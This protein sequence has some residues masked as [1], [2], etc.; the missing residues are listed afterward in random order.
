LLRIN[1]FDQPAV[2]ESKQL[3]REYLRHK[4][5]AKGQTESVA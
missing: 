3:A 1:A 4:Q 5:H 2:E